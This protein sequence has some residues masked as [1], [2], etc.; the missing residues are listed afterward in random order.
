MLVRL[1]GLLVALI[2]HQT[3]KD[4]LFFSKS[5]K[6]ERIAIYGDILFV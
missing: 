3:P 2:R 6:G 4:F 5:V 1:C